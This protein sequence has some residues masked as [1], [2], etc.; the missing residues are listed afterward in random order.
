MQTKIMYNKRQ[1][2]SIYKKALKLINTGL[3]ICVCDA[4]VDAV[5]DKG[6]SYVWDVPEDFPEFAKKKPKRIRH[7]K[8]ECGAWWAFESKGIRVK[9]LNQ[10]IAETK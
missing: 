10:C 5:R 8:K 1:R 7:S 4:I 9:K 2:H 3:I 6:G